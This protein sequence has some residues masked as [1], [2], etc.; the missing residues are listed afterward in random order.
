[1]YCGEVNVKQEALPAFISTAEAL[2]IKGLTESSEHPNMTATHQ[3]G[4]TVGTTIVK[5]NTMNTTRIST[6]PVQQHSPQSNTIKTS[7]SRVAKNIRPLTVE[8]KGESADEHSEE[9]LQQIETVSAVHTLK[10]T[11]PKSSNSTAKRTKLSTVNTPDPL[12]SVEQDKASLLDKV[13]DFISIPI[14]M[15]PK[16]EPHD[17]DT[18]GAVTSQQEPQDQDATFAE[19]ETYGEMTKYEDAYFT[20]A[21]VSIKPGQSFSD[22]Y[23]AAEQEQSGTDP[24]G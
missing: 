15:N 2:Q 9:K 24:Q 10:R 5:D 19:D 16:S 23:S 20:E 8:Y 6:V 17:Y 22:S 3:S 1:M 13:D 7:I 18:T 12:E 11:L 4:Q 21:N 14:D